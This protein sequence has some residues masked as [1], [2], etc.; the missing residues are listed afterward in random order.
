MLPH[1]PGF[2]FVE[3]ILDV[4]ERTLTACRRIP[5]E[6]PWTSSHFPGNPIVPGVLIL[7]GMVQTCG[8]LARLL[9]RAPQ[10]VDVASTH[11]V[12]AS[13]KSLRLRRTVHPGVLLRYRATLEV[14]VGS[15]YSFHVAAIVDDSEVADARVC[16][17][18]GN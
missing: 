7:E 18:I 15:L 17:S 12:L 1:G 5:L 3:E 10:S 2:L 9:S 6:E 14:K 11:G 16:L 13:V 8:I 4:E